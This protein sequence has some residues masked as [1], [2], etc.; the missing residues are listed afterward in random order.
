[1]AQGTKTDTEFILFAL[2]GSHHQLGIVLC[3]SCVERIEE[4]CMLK[5]KGDMMERGIVKWFNAS[6]GY[7]FVGREGAP[8]VFVHYTGIEAEGYK[9][10]KEGDRVEFE[11]TKGPKGPQAARV[12]LID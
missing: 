4:I 5:G 6:K 11:V 7:G 2:T 1:M 12:R 3:V 8:D 10:L 9:S